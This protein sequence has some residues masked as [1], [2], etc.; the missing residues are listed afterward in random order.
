MRLMLCYNGKWDFC[1]LPYP[2]AVTPK[3]DGVRCVITKEGART[4]SGR[5][6]PNV[7]LQEILSSYPIGLDGEIITLTKGQRDSFHITSAK[8]RTHDILTD[9][10]FFVFD[11][12]H[13]KLNYEERMRGLI[14]IILPLN[15]EL[16]VPTLCYDEEDVRS[17]H[18]NVVVDGYEGTIIH[19]PQSPYKF[20]RTTKNEAW[21]FKYVDWIREEGMLKGFTKNEMHD[22][23]IGALIVST[24]KWGD[25]NIGSGFDLALSSLFLKE[26]ENFR[27]KFV[28]F[29]YRAGRSLIKPS[30]PIFCG[31]RLDED[32]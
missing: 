24:I 32:V 22:D 12:Q 2:C 16:L 1:D 31:I 21:M 28:T 15:C 20:G 17:F 30:M 7:Y 19:H 10:R 29:K 5:K 6:F 11:V 23:R 13:T 9:F 3:L 18:N 25:V 8:L 26:F 14:R 27:G 4:R